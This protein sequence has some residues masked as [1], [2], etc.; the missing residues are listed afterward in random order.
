M[1]APNVHVGGGRQLLRGLLRALEARGG[2]AAILDERFDAGFELA[3]AT[4]VIRVRP[5][6][7]Q[8]LAAEFRLKGL[9]RAGSTVLCFANL[10]P[11][12]R[13]HARVYL[14]LQNRYLCSDASLAGFPASARMQL[15]VERR[16][17]R[18]RAANVD[19]ILVQTASVQREVERHVNRPAR[20]LPF[21]PD[22][23]LVDADSRRRPGDPDSMRF[24]YVASGEP[25]KNHRRL[26]EAWRTL[27]EA[28]LRP[29]LLL[30]IDPD[31]HNPLAVEVDTFTKRHGLKIRNLGVLPPSE[32]TRWYGEADALIYPS[33]MESFG[34]PLLESSAAGLP[35]IAAE[36]DYVRDV[37]NPVETFDPDSPLSVARAVRRF[38]GRADPPQQPL[39]AE[40]FVQRLLEPDA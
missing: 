32:L 12:F 27:A 19:V 33:F 11:L 7:T 37:V 31:R 9:A 17:M 13:L 16:W 29:S 35:I 25:H 38:M 30:T 26:I 15:T 39:S 6:I 2:Y 36:R 23:A 1:H 24:L 28:G 14:F 4:N 3:R 10:P 40:A 8:R 20:V 22:R 18:W 21:L 5:R 34:L